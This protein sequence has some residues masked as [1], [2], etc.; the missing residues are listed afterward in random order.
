MSAWML[1]AWALVAYATSSQRW[2]LQT[3]RGVA[4]VAMYFVAYVLVGLIF[5]LAT[6]YPYFLWF[7][8]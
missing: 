4:P 3:L 8:R 7:T 6:D 1:L 5:F 2:K